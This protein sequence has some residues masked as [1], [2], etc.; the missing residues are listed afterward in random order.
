MKSCN[1][2]NLPPNQQ[3]MAL[4]VVLIFLLLLTMLGVNTMGAS[5]LEERMAANSQNLMGAFQTSES[6]IAEVI[7]NT[8]VTNAAAGSNTFTPVVN[9]YTF[10]THSTTVTTTRMSSTNASLHGYTLDMFDGVPIDIVADTQITSNGARSTNTQGG[11]IPSW[12]G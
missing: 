11:L 9:S 7:G 10:G 12:K 2:I 1:N 6:A 3:G 4:I 8:A 5:N